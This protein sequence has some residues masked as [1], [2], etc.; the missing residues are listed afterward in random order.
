[1]QMRLQFVHTP[2]DS[3]ASRCRPAHPGIGWVRQEEMMSWNDGR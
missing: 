1:M 2:T 3:Q